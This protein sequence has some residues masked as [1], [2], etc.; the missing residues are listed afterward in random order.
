[1][2]RPRWGVLGSERGQQLPS[3]DDALV[4]YVEACEHVN[5]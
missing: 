1:V 4:R 2:P 3:L 5:K